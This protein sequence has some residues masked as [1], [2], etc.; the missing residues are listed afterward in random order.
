[1]KRPGHSAF[2]AVVIG[3]CCIINHRASDF[4]YSVLIYAI[5]LFFIISECISGKIKIININLIKFLY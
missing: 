2:N 5:T 4:T 1:A 3:L